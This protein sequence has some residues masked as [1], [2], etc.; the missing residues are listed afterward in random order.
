MV[1]R[2]NHIREVGKALSLL[3]RNGMETR[4]L[5]VRLRWTGRWSG[6]PA[7]TGADNR[8]S[9]LTHMRDVMRQAGIS[10]SIIGMIATG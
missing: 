1:K 3:F 7:A 8:N 9:A 6:L 4:F 10:V 2:R 5:R